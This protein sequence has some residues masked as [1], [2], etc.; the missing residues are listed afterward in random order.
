MNFG[1]MI[2]DTAESACRT[3]NSDGFIATIK[4]VTVA[5]PGDNATGCGSSHACVSPT[6]EVIAAPGGVGLHMTDMDVIFEDPP[7]GCARPGNQCQIADQNRYVW[8]NNPN[9]SG[10]VKRN[11]PP[12]EIYVYAEHLAL[13]ELGHTLGLPDFYSLPG[14]APAAHHSANYDPRLDAELAIMNKHWDAKTIQPTDIAQL[15]AI[16]RLHSSHPAK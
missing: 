4:T 8:T 15:D 1:L 13:H 5:S 12:R 3:R 14:V 11:R 7:Y 10:I 2:C 6:G 9:M 16:Y